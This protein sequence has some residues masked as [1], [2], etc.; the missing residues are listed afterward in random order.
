MAEVSR[1]VRTIDHAAVESQEV[2]PEQDDAA[3]VDMSA[4]EPAEAAVAEDEPSIPPSGR[5]EKHRYQSIFAVKFSPL[6]SRVQCKCGEY[7]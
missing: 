2:V 3:K 4:S 5:G 1:E 7:I 6:R